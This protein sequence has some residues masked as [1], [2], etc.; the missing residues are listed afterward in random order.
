MRNGSSHEEHSFKAPFPEHCPKE[1]APIV[2][3][4]VCEHW[5][6]LKTYPYPQFYF[7]SPRCDR[8]CTWCSRRSRSCSCL[9]Q[10]DA[11]QIQHF[12]FMYRTTNRADIL[13]AL[14]LFSGTW[15]IQC[16]H[17][18][19]TLRWIAEA[20]LNQPQNLIAPCV[21]IH[22]NLATRHDM[23]L[24]SCL[25]CTKGKVWRPG[26]LTLSR[27]AAPPSCPPSRLSSCHL[28]SI[29]DLN[30]STNAKRLS[31]VTTV[32]SG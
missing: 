6:K 26:P 20:V 2:L 10:T 24:V 28:S 22:E 21:R 32:S 19:W 30:P 15:G 31:A 7:K 17:I 13:S 12:L 9:S 11:N 8:R 23:H 16:D 27:Q 18:H 4:S 5:L 14:P 3:D 25:Y 1:F 29:I